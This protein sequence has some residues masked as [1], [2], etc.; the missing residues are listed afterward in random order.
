MTDPH[1]SLRPGA[2]T[3]RDFL[4]V[5]AQEYGF[6]FLVDGVPSL[7]ALS[8]AER[9]RCEQAVMRGVAMW[10]GS[11]RAGWEVLNQRY[12][13]D[14]KPDGDG[15]YNIDNDPQRYRMPWSFAGETQGRWSC[16]DPLGEIPIVRED[17]ARFVSDDWTAAFPFGCAFRR[18]T[19]TKPTSEQIPAW[20][21]V[22]A[23]KPSQELT[24]TIAYRANVVGMQNESDVFIA[25]DP[26]DRSV[27][28]AIAYMVMV[29]G[30]F[31][32]AEKASRK[33]DFDMAL[34]EALAIDERA[35]TP[36]LGVLS[37]QLGSPYFCIDDENDSGPVTPGDLIVNGV[38]LGS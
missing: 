16:A 25:G 22:F 30:K 5:A 26:Y 23:P 36:S 6:D 9:Y 33:A 24:V 31:P 34:A 1:S 12:T 13:I 2:L 27:E 11:N 8:D 29:L 4:L 17:Q 3:Y 7:D 38:N 37:N 19:Q 20:E 35:R 10:V 21:A 18:V 15:P 28:R 32:D 14:L